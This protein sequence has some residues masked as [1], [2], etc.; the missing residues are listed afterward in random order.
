MVVSSLDIVGLSSMFSAEQ[1][2]T[3][4]NTVI[5]QYPDVF[6]AAALRNPVISSG[7]ISTS[8]IADWYYAEFGL[9]YPV[10]SQPLGSDGTELLPRSTA[11]APPPILI[12]PDVY[13]QLFVASPIAHVEKVKIPVLLLIGGSDA[14]VAPTQGVGYYHALKAVKNKV[15]K[16][17]D[18]DMLWFPEE[19]HP[20]DGVVAS[21]A[22]WF[23]TV[24]WFKRK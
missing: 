7:E 1:H 17:D 24:E 21:K 8:D 22:S 16:T 5:G 14:R 10:Q 3:K 4:C 23:R 9:E 12:T 19:S 18:V 15:G 13:K 2:L 20:L 11:S 6:T